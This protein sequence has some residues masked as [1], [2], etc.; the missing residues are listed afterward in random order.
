MSNFES[1][2]QEYIRQQEGRYYQQIHSHCHSSHDP[3]PARQDQSNYS[4][5]LPSFQSQPFHPPSS[6][7]SSPQRCCTFGIGDG[8]IRN[9]IFFCHLPIFGET[10]LHIHYFWPV[11]I[12]AMTISSAY[13]SFLSFI[14]ALIMSCPILFGTVLIH[15]LGHAA[16]A[17]HYGGQVRLILLW[18]LG[19]VAY[20]SMFGADNPVADAMIAIAGPLTHIPQ[21]FFW[22]ILLAISNGGKFEFIH[23][24]LTWETLWLHTCNGALILQFVIFLFNLLPAFPLDGGRILAACLT[25][26]HVETSRV[27]KICAIIGGVSLPSL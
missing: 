5:F 27:H 17:I 18:P 4:T 24:P 20:L 1:Q 3:P 7:L 6:I 21:V 22:S 9:S 23:L 8:P 26:G 13:I 11:L 10:P 16:M 14:F 19:G 15:E 25:M 2:Q 12:I